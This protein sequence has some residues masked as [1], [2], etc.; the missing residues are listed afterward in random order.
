MKLHVENGEVDASF[1]VASNERYHHDDL[2]GECSKC[3]CAIF[4]RPEPPYLIPFICLRCAMPII[5]ADKDINVIV[6]SKTVREVDALL[7]KPCA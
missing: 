2:E 5:R 1:R 7:K 4:Y 6:S 3:K